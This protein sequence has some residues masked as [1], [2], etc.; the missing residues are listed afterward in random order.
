MADMHRPG[1]VGRD[2]FDIDLGAVTD[3]A[4]AVGRAFAQHGAQLA[5]PDLGLQG[6]IDESG[7]SD[8]DGSDQIVG[9]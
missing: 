1:R 2:V 7:T 4:F 5:G 9:A 3:R 6:K 8:L